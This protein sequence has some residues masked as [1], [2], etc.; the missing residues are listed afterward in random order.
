MKAFPQLL[1]AVLR[2][3]RPLMSEAADESSTN[4][5][6]DITMESSNAPVSDPATSVSSLDQTVDGEATNVSTA[7]L[8]TATPVVTAVV[9]TQGVLAPTAAGFRIEV[10]AH[11]VRIIHDPSAPTNE[12][13]TTKYDDV[14]NLTVDN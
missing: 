7:S 2:G 1:P 14:S 12:N 9:P 10:I 4:K 11:G 13:N 5:V 6:A 8:S 3:E